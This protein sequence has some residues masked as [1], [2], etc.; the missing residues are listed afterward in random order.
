MRVILT[1]G[2]TGGHIYPALA[3][4][5]EIMKDPKAEVLFI[6][7]KDRMEAKL[8]PEAGYKFIG[9]NLQGF[10]GNSHDKL[11]AL[12][13]NREARKEC[14]KII[15][16]F[17]PQVIIGFGNYV[18]VPVIQAGKKLGI[19]CVIH[20][21]NSLPGLANR[22][23]SLLATK[24][25]TSY[26]ETEKYFPAKKVEL[27]GNPRASQAARQ[28]KDL[29]VI[30]QL[31]LDPNKKTVLI[32]M[33]SLGSHSVNKVMVEVLKHLG[34]KDFQIIEVTGEKDYQTFIDQVPSYSN[35]KVLPYCDQLALM[36]NCDLIVCR[37]GATSASEIMALGLPSIIIPSPYVPNNHQ[38]YNALAMVKAGCAYELPEDQLTSTSL[39]ELIQRL[40]YD[41]KGLAQMRLKAEQLGFPLAVHKIAALLQH[42]TGERYE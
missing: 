33:G 2:G 3:L 9:L 12:K 14:L 23:L 7:S 16:E 22:Y 31:G 42:L 1:T 28:K 32:V 17:K 26:P 29:N 34:D 11:Q 38:H 39:V 21:Q 5:T 6:G 25:I 30:K 13:L 15:Q 19:P 4:T 37:G 24:V 8:I 40:I 35:I 41:D 36:A 10:N 27:L 18:T 20:E